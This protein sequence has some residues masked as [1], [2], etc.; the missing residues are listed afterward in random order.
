MESIEHDLAKL[1]KIAAF[2]FCIYTGAQQV[3]AAAAMRLSLEN[4]QS[5]AL[6]VLAAHALP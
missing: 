1:G 5:R 3:P 6:H 4:C 2:S